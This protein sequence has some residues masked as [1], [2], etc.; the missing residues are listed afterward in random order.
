MKYLLSCMF[1][2]ISVFWSTAQVDFAEMEMQLEEIA[3][4]LMMSDDLAERKQAFER[5][6]VELL[7]FLKSDSSFHHPFQKLKRISLLQAPDSTFK[8]FTGQLYIDED[9]YQ[10]YGILQHRD[11]PNNPVVLNDRSADVLELEQDILTKDDWY[12]AVY[13]NIKSFTKEGKTYYALFGFDTYQMFENRKVV[14]VLHFD[15]FTPRF[16][17]P[18][19]SDAHGIT[20]NR[21]VIQYAADVSIKLN[22]DK[23]LQLIVFDNLIPMKSPYKKKKISMVPDGSYSGYQLNQ[24]GT[25]IY[26]DKIF[27]TTLA[28]PPREKPVLDSESGRDIFGKKKN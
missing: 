27:H 13:Y 6:Q 5:V 10:Y 19:F 3:S 23:D 26:I 25:W 16:G 9:N 1:S 12:G 2:V 11:D 22:Y 18:V 20:K 8:V 24:A 7:A 21:I 17:S 15:A 14:E 28:A 4:T